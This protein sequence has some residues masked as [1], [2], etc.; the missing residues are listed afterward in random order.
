MSVVVLSALRVA[1]YHCADVSPNQEI[2]E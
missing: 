1:A 2:S